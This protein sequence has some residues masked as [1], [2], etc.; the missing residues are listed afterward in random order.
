[1]RSSCF[2]GKLPLV[3]LWIL[4][5]CNF[6]LCKHFRDA[7]LRFP[8]ARQSWCHQSFQFSLRVF[9]NFF[10]NLVIKI[11]EVHSSQSSKNYRVLASRFPF[12][13]LSILSGFTNFCPY[14]W[15]HVSGLV[16][17][18]N[19]VSLSPEHTY[20]L[21]S[22]FQWSKLRETF[23]RIW[24][25]SVQIDI[26]IVI[27]TFP[28]H[29]VQISVSSPCYISVLQWN[30]ECFFFRHIELNSR[31]IVMTIDEVTLDRPEVGTG[32]SVICCF[33]RLRLEVFHWKLRS[34]RFVAVL[35]WVLSEFVV[36]SWQFCCTM[37]YRQK[38]FNSFFVFAILL[39]RWFFEDNFL[40][41]PTVPN[42]P[43]Q[44]ISFLKSSR[45]QLISK[46]D[47]RWYFLAKLM[48]PWLVSCRNRVFCNHCS[49]R[50]CWPIEWFSKSS[51]IRS[52]PICQE[53]LDISQI[54]TA[55]HGNSFFY[56]S[57]CSFC[58]AVCLGSMRCRSS[59]IQW[60]IFTGFAKFQWIACVDNFCFLRR[61]EELS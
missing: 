44:N 60:W 35:E 36:S 55:F 14:F 11:N 10:A 49:K 4:L 21:G 15:P 39:S 22:F 25:A 30:R 57:Y 59:V 42:L 7:S 43:N 31:F 17:D 34:F 28:L 52:S 12:L 19:F 54:A 29:D 2:V 45:D 47:S 61:L 33:C 27:D 18:W 48:K 26:P 16:V 8:F 3:V 5:R 40:T 41:R 13:F 50:N 1:M 24:Q 32:F 9:E 56:S 53:V 6:L 20:P 51:F 37:C 46:K 38:E 58:N 23:P